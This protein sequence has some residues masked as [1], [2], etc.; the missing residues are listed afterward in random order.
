MTV[1]YK[2]RPPAAASRFAVARSW[3][4]KMARPARPALELEHPVGGF[5]ERRTGADAGHKA[6]PHHVHVVGQI[7]DEKER[8]IATAD[9]HGHRAGGVTWRRQEDEGAVTEK[10]VRG[11]EGSERRVEWLARR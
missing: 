10:V 4:G 5:P 6:A 2:T 11:R 9:E 3:A 7:A 1:R 8:R